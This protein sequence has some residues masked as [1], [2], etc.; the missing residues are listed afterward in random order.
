MRYIPEWQPMYS[1]PR[2]GT[3]ILITNG[4]SEV[5]LAWF[6][7]ENGSYPWLIVDDFEHEV[8][9]DDDKII[10]LNAAMEVYAKGWMPLPDSKVAQ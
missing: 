3:R 9:V 8:S 1:A 7:K 4:Y 5:R 10:R 2:D 6:D